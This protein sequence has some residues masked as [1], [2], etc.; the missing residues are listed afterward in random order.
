MVCPR[1]SKNFSVLSMAQL[2]LFAFVAL[3]VALAFFKR[4]LKPAYLVLLVAFGLLAVALALALSGTDIMSID[5]CLDRG[6]RW[7]EIGGACELDRGGRP[8]KFHQGNSRRD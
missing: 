7:N 6:G 3:V 2:A 1:V 8:D 5:S 4:L